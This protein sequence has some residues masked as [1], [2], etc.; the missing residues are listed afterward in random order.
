MG[1]ADSKPI[2]VIRQANVPKPTADDLFKFYTTLRK[3]H[4]EHKNT[5]ANA[6]IN[7]FS[8]G[9]EKVSSVRDL[10]TELSRKITKE[11]DKFNAM[12]K[13]YEINKQKRETIST[14]IIIPE[15]QA[16]IDQFE[17]FTRGIQSRSIDLDSKVKAIIGN[18]SVESEEI[19]TDMER[20]S[21]IEDMIEVNIIKKVKAYCDIEKKLS[22]A[23][24]DA[25]NEIRTKVK[26]FITDCTEQL[27]VLDSLQN[28]VRQAMLENTKNTDKADRKI[29]DEQRYNMNSELLSNIRLVLVTFHSNFNQSYSIANLTVK[30]SSQTCEQDMKNEGWIKKN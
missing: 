28:D 30:T 3:K 17:E 16:F 15:A 25:T 20:D 27:E 7:G 26:E 2:V 12:V 13:A 19:L 8:D 1:A 6:L 5:Y 21:S 29:V 9:T 18:C 22:E 23:F 24:K 11:I 14:E 10:C 4:N